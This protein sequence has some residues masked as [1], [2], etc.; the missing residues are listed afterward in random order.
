MRI[1]NQVCS[2]EQGKRIDELLGTDSESLFTWGLHIRNE[3]YVWEV[4]LRHSNGDH[5]N[6]LESYPAYTDAELLH[7]LPQSI[8]KANRCELELHKTAEGYDAL[9]V[10]HDPYY[11]QC[12]KCGEQSAVVLA[13]LLIHLLTNNLIDVNEINKV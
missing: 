6:C 8:D 12:R 10:E 5:G 7:I 13:D 11:E 3:D 9:Y 2:K 1:E 4:A